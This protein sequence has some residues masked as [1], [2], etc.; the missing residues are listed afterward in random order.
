MKN[1]IHQFLEE[2]EVVSQDE[3]FKALRIIAAVVLTFFVGCASHSI[4]V[5]IDMN[6]GT[7]AKALLMIVSAYFIFS[8]SKFLENDELKR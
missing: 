2:M 6:E 7:V 3:S 4:Y 8:I 1:I 5:Y